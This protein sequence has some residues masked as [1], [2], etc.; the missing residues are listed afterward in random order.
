MILNYS[1]ECR[2]IN[3]VQTLILK[4]KKLNIFDSVL[5]KC[6]YPSLYLFNIVLVVVV[7]NNDHNIDIGAFFPLSTVHFDHVSYSYSFHIFSNWWPIFIANI[8]SILIAFV[9]FFNVKNEY[10]W[11]NDNSVIGNVSKAHIN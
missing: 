1:I 2:T 3:N 9:F 10:W 8:S 4:K 6:C 5:L 7:W 11:E